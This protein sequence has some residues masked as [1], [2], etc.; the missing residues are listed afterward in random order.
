[1]HLGA[2]REDQQAL[3][4]GVGLFCPQ[5]PGQRLVLAPQASAASAVAA[6]WGGSRSELMDSWRGEGIV[7]CELAGSVPCPARATGSIVWSP[8]V[9]VTQLSQPALLCKILPAPLKHRRGTWDL[10]IP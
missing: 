3:G 10:G 4:G 8:L 7:W 2:S 9:Q 1:M 6:R 5:R